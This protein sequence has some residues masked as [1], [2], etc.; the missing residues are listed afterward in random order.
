M[1]KNKKVEEEVFE[2][3]RLLALT[4]DDYYEE[5]IAEV[6]DDNEKPWKHQEL[7]QWVKV[8]QKLLRLVEWQQATLEDLEQELTEKQ[9]KT[10]VNLLKVI[11][12]LKKEVNELKQHV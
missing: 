8:C 11:N 10:T 7:K 4:E 3:T 9:S 12:D 1:F 5:F 2:I 6:I